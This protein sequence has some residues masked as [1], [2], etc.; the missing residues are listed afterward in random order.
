ME[1]IKALVDKNNSEVKSVKKILISGYYGFD[2]AGDEAVLQAII[3]A[4]KQEAPFIKPVVL[5]ANPEKTTELYRVE[6]VHRFRFKDV[7]NAIRQ[8]D[9]LISGGG[10]LLQDETSKRSIPYYMGIIHLAQLF[11]KPTFIYAQG[12]GPVKRKG[13]YPLIRSGFNKTEYISVRDRESAFL[14]EKMKVSNNKVEIIVDPV[15][16]LSPIS[17][18]KTLK[19]LQKEQIN[20]SPIIISVRYWKEDKSYLNIIGQVADELIRLGEEIAFISMHEPSDREASK[21]VIDQMTEKPKLIDTYDARSL[22]GMIGQSKLVIGMRLH[23]LIFATSM[24]VP[25]IGITYDPKID[26][27]LAL[28]NQTPVGTTEDLEFNTMYDQ[29][30]YVLDHNEE[31]RIEVKNR[32]D[33]LREQAIRPAKAIRQYFNNSK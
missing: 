11:G 3:D 24:G 28:L 29:V 14:L 16:N 21:Y 20:Q 27:F 5:S 9:G 10:S 17:K 26:Q 19:I 4:L 12:I 31:S 1:Y 8:T 2:N 23:S 18:E 25:S 32:I 22:M 33:L 30:K 13:F 6:A 7:Y 15:L